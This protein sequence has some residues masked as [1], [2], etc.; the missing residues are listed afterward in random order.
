MTEADLARYFDERKGDLSQWETKPRRIRVRRGGPSTVFSI[1]FAP[2]ELKLIQLAATIQGM[3]VS[4]FVRRASLGAA[5]TSPGSDE[6][7][8]L[9]RLMGE[10]QVSLTEARKRMR[11]IGGRAPARGEIARRPL[12]A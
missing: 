5:T 7:E 9:M 2:E 1:R 8:A 12:E 6:Y 11:R 10:L 3:T 4:E